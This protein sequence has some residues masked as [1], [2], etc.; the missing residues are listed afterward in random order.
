MWHRRYKC[1]KLTFLFPICAFIFAAGFA[2]RVY[3]AFN[4]F[5]LGTYIASVFLIYISP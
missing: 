3:G 1:A 4:P 5:L 2:I